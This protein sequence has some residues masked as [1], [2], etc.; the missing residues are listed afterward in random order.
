M[1]I[2]M[3]D[4]KFEYDVAFSFLQEDEGIATKINDLIKGRLKTFLYSRAQEKIAGTDGEKTFGKIFG[5]EARIVAV[6]Y[7][8]GWGNSPWTRIEETAIRNRAYEEGYDFVL[9]IPT[10]EHPVLPAWLPKTR[11]WVGLARWGMEVAAGVIEARVQEAGGV[12]REESAVD[13]AQRLER[14]IKT[15]ANRIKFLGSTEGVGAAW[16]EVTALYQEIKIIGEEIVASTLSLGIKTEE[17]DRKFLI[18]INNFS[19]V[20]NWVVR[21]SNTLEDS[22]LVMFLYE[23]RNSLRGYFFPDE[24]REIKKW[25]YKFD[26]NGNGVFG[27]KEIKISKRF[28]TSKQLAEGIVK[29]LLDHVQR[30][31]FKD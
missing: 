14:Q 15:E 10:I 21:Y 4:N 25:E 3:E 27:W 28:F 8:E 23:G 12:L 9:F 1:N 31:K 30:E 7:R 16:E 17:M 11:I 26:L 6:F 20:I 24:S 13:H 29:T 2:N 5:E 22:L 19:V 18:N